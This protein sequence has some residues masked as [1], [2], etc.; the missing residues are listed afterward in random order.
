M[1]ALALAVWR[2]PVWAIAVM[3]ALLFVVG[4][5]ASMGGVF[6]ASPASAPGGV[7]SAPPV[8]SADHVQMQAGKSNTGPVQGTPTPT[9]TGTPPTVTRT[10][11]STATPTNTS[12]PC[13]QYTISQS[14]GATVVPAT[15]MVAGSNCDDCVVLIPIPFTFSLYSQSFTTVNASSNGNLQFNSAD[16]TY[17]NTCLPA[18]IFNYAILPHWDDQVLTGTGQGIFTLVTGTAPNRVF[19]IEWKGGYFSGGGT[20]D[21]E[22]RLFEN[23]NN[24]EIIY[25]T[26]TQGGSSA[27]VGVQLGTGA[28]FTQF[29]CNTAGTLTAGLKLTFTAPV[30]TPPTDTPTRTPTS[31]PTAVCTPATFSDV[32]PTDYFYTAV[33]YLTCL[34]AIS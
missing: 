33:Q 5:G 31:T 16:T 22:V 2:H 28:A 20:V 25:G 26:V 17:T 13:G 24:F 15:T 34:G 29:E 32:N 27:T 1:K 14:T 9:I 19:N 7:V 10:R 23:S 18:T 12:T 21:Y 11:T 6:A 30:C 3:F 4:I 8:Q